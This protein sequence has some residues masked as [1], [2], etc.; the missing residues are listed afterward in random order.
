M[1][2]VWLALLLIDLL[3]NK[4][5]RE[6]KSSIKR[7][8]SLSSPE[9]EVSSLNHSIEWVI[10]L[11]CPSSSTWKVLY[12]SAT[13]FTLTM[14]SKWTLYYLRKS[15]EVRWPQL[16]ALT[17]LVLGNDDSVNRQLQGEGRLKICDRY[18]EDEDDNTKDSSSYESWIQSQQYGEG[19][20]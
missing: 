4:V 2:Q 7:G 12:K 10:K 3:C 14:R 8:K 11:I 19:K 16:E 5:R 6:Y 1:N 9:W 18:V 13:W 17:S 20:E 15:M